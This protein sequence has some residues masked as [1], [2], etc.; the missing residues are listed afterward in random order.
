MRQEKALLDKR[1]SLSEHLFMIQMIVTYTCGRCE[2]PNIVRNEH[3]YKGSQ[4]YHGKDCGRY[5]TVNAQQGY[6][7]T[8]QAQA[9]RGVVERLLCLSRRTIRRWLGG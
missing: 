2:S 9:K 5:G 3:D 7:A 8:T 4:K 1:P 6:D